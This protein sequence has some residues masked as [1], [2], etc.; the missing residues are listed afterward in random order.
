[1]TPDQFLNRVLAT[2]DQLAFTLSHTSPE[3]Q[4]AWL[5]GFADR[6]CAQWGPLFAPH[7]EPK[8]VDGMIAD[9]AKRVR[10]RRDQI[11]AAGVGT[12]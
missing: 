6:I 8:D 1:M 5:Q 4:E 7:L 9:L 12:A 2:V 11:E 3:R 10:K